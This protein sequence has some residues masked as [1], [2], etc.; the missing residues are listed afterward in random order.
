MTRTPGFWLRAAR[1]AA[2]MSVALLATGC[3]NG[4]LVDAGGER[5][6]GGLAFVLLAFFFWIFFAA[7]FYMDRV[8]KR[9]STS[10]EE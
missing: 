10:E 7:I 9:R 1:L 4:Q 2:V 8:R 3:K 6:A 5:G